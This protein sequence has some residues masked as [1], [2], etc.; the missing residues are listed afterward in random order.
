MDTGTK[1]TIILSIISIIVA[2]AAIIVT[3]VLYVIPQRKKKKEAKEQKKQQLDTSFKEYL[4][5]IYIPMDIKD[6]QSGGKVFSFFE[7]FAE[8]VKAKKLKSRYICLLGDIGSGKTAALVHLHQWYIDKYSDKSSMPSHIR[9]YSLNGDYQKLMDR[10]DAE[11]PTQDR[12]NCILLLDALDECKKAQAS[13]E[14]ESENNP[15]KFMEKLGKDTE[16]FEWVV[17]SCRRQFFQSEEFQP[18]KA[19]VPG[20]VKGF[21]SLP[22]WQELI[23]EPFSQKQVESFLDERFGEGQNPQKDEAANIVYGCEDVFLRPLI[24]SNIDIILEECHGR[25]NLT[26]K[27]ILDAVIMNWIK[28]EAM[29]DEAKEKELLKDSLCIAA[30]MYKHNLIYLNDDD[31]KKMCEEHGIDDQGNLLRV[32]SLLT[33]DAKEGFRF[34]HQSFYEH[35]LAYW[36]FLHPRDIGSLLGLLESTLPAYVEILNEFGRNEGKM[37]QLMDKENVNVYTIATGLYNIG[38]GLQNLNHF[39]ESEPFY[40]TALESFRAL[41]NDQP[42]KFIDDVAM[43]LGNL[44]ILHKNINHHDEAEKEFDEVLKIY[45]ELADKNPDV[46]KLY[47]AGTLNNLGELHRNTNRYDKAEKEYDEALKIYRELAG[48]NPDTYMPKV[49]TAL[50]NFAILHRNTNRYDE[51]E[52]EYGE[53]LKIRQEL[54]KKNPHAYMPDIADTLNNLAILHCYTNRYDK[55]AKEYGEALKIYRELAKENPDVYMPDVAMTLN[56]LANLHSNTNHYDEA[57]KEYGEALKIRRKLA[58]KYPDAYM[59]DVATTLNNLGELHRKSNCY[60]EAEK[61][62]GEALKIR[63]ELT[64]KNPD[65]YMP[66]VAGTLNNLALLHSDTNRYDEAEKEYGEALKIYRE[67]AG[68]NPDA[69]MPDVAMTLFNMSFLHKDKG[70]LADAEEKAKES[71]EKYQQMAELSHD[72]FDKY[73]EMAK[74][75]LA[76]IQEARK[77]PKP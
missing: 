21:G 33:N 67:L 57:E 61:E 66:Y 41:E 54:A 20:G 71:L 23:L 49:A 53:A 76:R 63:R 28:R 17:V 15:R 25:E 7:H 52:E 2:I 58:D 13:L 32:Q 1:I 10:I 12:S 14:K 64:K 30:Y 77:K 73:V 35:L 5:S 70:E 39:G 29:G 38:C 50:N 24:L 8:I 59:P 16:D 18:G 42:G 69:Y 4:D 40:Q 26:M 55:A 27:V 3:I 45:R 51:A 36:F 68:K 62:Y 43:T 74:K 9:L 19:K 31:Y 46:Y 37:L 47:V 34:A 60:D 22:Y 11:I 56:N 65:A 72:A 48:K 6:V 75:L 44:A